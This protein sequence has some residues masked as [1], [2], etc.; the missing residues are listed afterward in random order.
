M[1]AN[2][3]T[4]YED[5]VYS[6]GDPTTLPGGG[7]TRFSTLSLSFTLTH[8]HTHTHTHT[9][10]PACM[11]PFTYNGVVY[12]DC[13]TANEPLGTSSVRTLLIIP[14]TQYLKISKHPQ[15][16][17]QLL[18]PIKDIWAS[19]GVQP[20]LMLGR[21]AFRTGHRLALSTTDSYETGRAH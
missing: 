18:Q 19:R 4:V 8:S 12:N 5:Y 14:F 6:S 13:I 21:T 10:G 15:P 3:V 2:G 20:A 16:T 11:F 17:Q 9:V 1:D 7:G